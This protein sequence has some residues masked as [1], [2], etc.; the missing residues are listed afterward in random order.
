M[1][2]N[3]RCLW[4]LPLDLHT[5]P[6]A[7]RA[8]SS[9]PPLRFVEDSLWPPL[10]T[11]KNRC[12]DSLWLVG[13]GR[14]GVWGLREVGSLTPKLGC[15]AGRWCKNDPQIRVSGRSMMQEWPQI[16]VSDRSMMQEWP[17]DSMLGVVGRVKR[18]PRFDAR[19][20]R[21]GKMTPQIWCSGWSE[22]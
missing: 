20:G 4:D 8:S 14:S 12:G 10:G 5:T 2:L 7:L 1:G 22:G 6:Q 18:P 17:P 15:R 16:W 3:S 11:A 21:K 19:G 13:F 9:R